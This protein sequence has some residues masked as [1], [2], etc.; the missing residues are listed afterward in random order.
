MAKPDSFT[1]LNETSGEVSGVRLPARQVLMNRWDGRV[2]ARWGLG[3]ELAGPRGPPKCLQTRAGPD[4]AHIGPATSPPL[5][6]QQGQ[7]QFQG[8]AKIGPR[9]GAL[10]TRH[11]ASPPPG[12]RRGSYRPHEPS[13]ELVMFAAPDPAILPADYLWLI[14]VVAVFMV[15]FWRITLRI[16]AVAFIVLIAYAVLMLAGQIDRLITAG[17]TT[18][19]T[20]GQ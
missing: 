2:A 14:V 17:T 16:I 7:R 20:Q 10:A 4:A 11:V 9:L 15:I 13:G 18:T 6:A 3:T 8:S 1:A 12:H 5:A 19:V